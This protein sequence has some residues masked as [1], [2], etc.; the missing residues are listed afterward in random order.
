[1]LRRVFIGGAAA[2]IGAAAAQPA[3][4]RPGLDALVKDI[5]A[6]ILAE[7]PGAKVEI[8]YDPE[9]PK[10]PLMILAFRS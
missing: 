6:V 8:T 10:L 5:E 3:L 4:C 1:M 2:G 9:D 7:M